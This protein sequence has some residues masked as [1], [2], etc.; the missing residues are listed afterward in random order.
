MGSVNRNTGVL[1]LWNCH[2]SQVLH[3]W[4]LDIENVLK[5]DFAIFF[6]GENG[7]DPDSLDGQCDS[8]PLSAYTSDLDANHM[9]FNNKY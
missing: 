5:D 1:L 8:S 9:A 3:I 6:S 7:Q 2:R 4:Q